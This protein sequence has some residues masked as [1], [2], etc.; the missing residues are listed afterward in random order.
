VITLGEV[1]HRAVLLGDAA[2]ELWFRL[3]NQ[4]GGLAHADLTPTGAT[5]D[6]ALSLGIRFL[7]RA[8]RRNGAWIDFRLPPGASDEWITAHV[9]FALENVASA[10]TLTE[11][12]ADYLARSGADRGGW[13]YNRRVRVD[14]DSTA[15]ALIVLRKHG[16]KPPKGIVGWLISNQGPSGGFPTY[17]PERGIPANGWQVEHPDVTLLVIES[18]R[19][20]GAGVEA[21]QAAIKWLQATT[22]RSVTSYWWPSAS[23]A[24][25]AQVRTSFAAADAAAQ[26]VELLGKSQAVPESAM[27]VEA[28]ALG[29]KLGLQQAKN[30]MVLLLR[31]QLHDGSWHC[32]PCLR[33]TEPTTMNSRSTAPGPVYAGTRRTFST[34]HAVAALNELSKLV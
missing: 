22:R 1:G 11:N 18:L 13:G 14:C 8:Q 3:N 5:I 26:A 15:Q 17:E 2:S 34:A 4:P 7:E 30:A 24:I 27:L 32:S 21:Q 19:R 20:L 29:G 9:A 25:W 31:E 23:Y 6:R 16:I 33:V 12:A 28:A 10:C